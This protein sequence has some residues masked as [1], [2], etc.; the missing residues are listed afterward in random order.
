MSLLQCDE[1]IKKCIEHWLGNIVVRC[2]FLF[3]LFLNYDLI[4]A[5]EAAITKKNR[6]MKTN[7]HALH[8]KM[9][10]KTDQRQ[11]NGKK[12]S[13]NKLNLNKS[14]RA[15]LNLLNWKCDQKCSFHWRT[16]CGFCLWFTFCNSFTRPV[17]QFAVCKF[18]FALFYVSNHCFFVVVLYSALTHGTGTLSP[19]AIGYEGTPQF[20]RDSLQYE[21]ESIFTNTANRLQLLIRSVCTGDCE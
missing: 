6:K 21:K 19:H 18:R 1:L 2:V 3:L 16:L 5:E 11:W 20:R 4:A 8:T 7:N 12:V 14:G 17:G 15:L 10:Q 13:F 9:K